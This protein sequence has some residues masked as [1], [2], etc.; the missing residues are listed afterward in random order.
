MIQLTCQ[1]DYRDVVAEQQHSADIAVHTDSYLELFA[2]PIGAS[3]QLA[4]MGQPALGTGELL[5]AIGVRI[6]DLEEVAG[7]GD[8]SRAAYALRVRIAAI[9][10]MTGEVATSD[11]V[12]RFVGSRAQTGWL[13]FIVTLP[14]R[15]GF[16]EVRVSLQQGDDRGATLASTIQPAGAAFAASDLV[17]GA[18][19]GA[20]SWRRDG[21]VVPMTPFSTYAAGGAVLIYQELYGLTRGTKYRTTISLR[22]AG[23]PKAKSAI[24]FQDAASG[25]TMA[26]SRRL[27]LDQVKPGTYDLVVEV[28]EQT[29]GRSVRRARSIT[30]G[31]GN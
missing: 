24:S 4:A 10:S 27:T 29:T 13:P 26:S 14:I 20:A 3:I 21:G 18:E 31:P 8:A 22:K 25:P 17:L 11:T 9:D 15:K 7:A 12:R 28:Q 6:E 30:V 5:A 23:D 16:K 19:M 2:H 1:A